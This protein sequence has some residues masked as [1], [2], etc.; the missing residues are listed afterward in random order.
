MH[1]PW[2]AIGALRGIL[3]G[4]VIG[5]PAHA[6]V[7]GIHTES[8]GME[9]LVDIASD[10]DSNQVADAVFQA[11]NEWSHDSETAA[12]DDGSIEE[13]PAAE[14]FMAT[15]EPGF[16]DGSELAGVESNSAVPLPASVWLFGSGLLLLVSSSK[17]IKS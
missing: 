16:V 11:G 17:R 15:T 13:G 10:S 2:Y 3:L 5:A 7:I 6:S 9:S 4:A 1:S 8:Q 12:D 14:L